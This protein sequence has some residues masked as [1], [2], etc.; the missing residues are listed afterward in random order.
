MNYGEPSIVSAILES[1]RSGWI[2][3]SADWV[4]DGYPDFRLAEEPHEFGEI[5]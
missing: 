2:E 5:H 4:F 3:L 1:K